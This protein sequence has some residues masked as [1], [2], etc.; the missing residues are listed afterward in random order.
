[1]D[2]HIVQDWPR[3]AYH[4]AEILEGLTVCWCRIED[5]HKESTEIEDLRRGL[6]ETVRLLTTAIKR[7]VDVQREYQELVDSNTRLRN[8]LV[9]S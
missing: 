3:I 6:Q 2:A 1:M 8:L 9:M 5:E 4:R 7:T